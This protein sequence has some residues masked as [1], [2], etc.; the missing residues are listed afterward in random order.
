MPVRKHDF[1]FFC[2]LNLWRKL[3]HALD[4]ISDANGNADNMVSGY[5]IATSVLG[6]T[7]LHSHKYDLRKLIE[8]ILRLSGAMSTRIRISSR[9]R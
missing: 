2:G 4:G 5:M 8:S 1:V 3:P 7:N 6:N 9:Y